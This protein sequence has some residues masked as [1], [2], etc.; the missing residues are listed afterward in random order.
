MS[1]RVSSRHGSHAEIDAAGTA[2]PTQTE[3][4]NATVADR[5]YGSGNAGST[6]QFVILVSPA[7]S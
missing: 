5:R 3:N 4:L 2:A 6:F 1:A 7:G